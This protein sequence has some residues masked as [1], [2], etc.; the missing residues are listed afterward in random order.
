MNGRTT[1][2]K[3]CGQ[4]AFDVAIIGGGITGAALYHQLCAQGYR[5]LLVDKGDFACG[6]SQSSGMMV[7]GGILY[8]RRLDIASVLRFSHARDQLL[9]HYPAL[10]APGSFCYL[11]PADN[12][13][14]RYLVLSSLYAYWLLGCLDRK[15]PTVENSF[16]EQSLLGPER[17]SCALSYEEGF[18]KDSDC[19][20]VLQ[21]ITPYQSLP[22]H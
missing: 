18:L 4:T 3:N 7:W 16:D 11:P 10:V 14:W 5:V 8:L 17:F 13:L 21:W 6:S 9:R 1:L 2:L 20:F 12:L 22:D 15:P 19:R